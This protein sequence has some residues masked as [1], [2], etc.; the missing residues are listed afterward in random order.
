VHAV[1]HNW[2]A[3]GHAASAD[4]GKTWRWYGGHCSQAEGP[5]SID[6]S[7]S[8]WPKTFAFAGSGGK[9]LSPARRERP[10]IVLD[11]TTK[12]VIA[13]TNALQ[14]SPADTTQTLVQEAVAGA[15]STPTTLYIGHS[16]S[17]SNAGTSI[18]APLASCRGAV[19]KIAASVRA[20]RGVPLGGFEVKIAPGTYSYNDSTSCGA[21]EFT[22]TAAAPIIVRGTSAEEVTFDGTVV[23]DATQL[24]PVTKT[25]L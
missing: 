19:T 3:G 11:P 8:V 2:K 12:K 7:R 23:L 24:K 4:R 10:H 5:S 18:S 13:L 1:V 16:G 6:W 22:A 17:D 15:A 25:P 21:V 14:L 9:Q 20:N